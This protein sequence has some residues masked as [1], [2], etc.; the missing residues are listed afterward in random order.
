[1]LKPGNKRVALYF[2]GYLKG[3]YRGDID[4]FDSDKKWQNYY[5]YE[6]YEGIISLP[7]SSFVSS[8]HAEASKA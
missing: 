7:K 2:E 5:N 1:M 4:L 8:I 3:K 6:I